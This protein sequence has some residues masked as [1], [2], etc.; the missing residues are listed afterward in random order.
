MACMN[1]CYYIL[2]D[3]SLFLNLPGKSLK[4]LKL[5]GELSQEWA[6]YHHHGSFMG[7]VRV[8]TDLERIQKWVY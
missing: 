3:G 2:S 4:D 1:Q 5:L 8:I 7:N 6:N